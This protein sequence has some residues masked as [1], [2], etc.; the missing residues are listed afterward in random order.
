M[1]RPGPVLAN[2]GLESLRFVKPVYPGDTIQATLT[3]KQ[4]TAKEKREGQVPQ[5]VVAWDVEVKN[6]NDELGGGV[7]DPDTGPASS[8]V[9]PKKN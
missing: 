5:G 9:T 3:V 4:K 8:G 6:Q 2:Y 7:H 1:P